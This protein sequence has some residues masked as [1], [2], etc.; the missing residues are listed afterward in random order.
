MLKRC[1]PPALL[2]SPIPIW[3]TGSLD[4]ATLLGKIQPSAASSSLQSSAVHKM[5]SAMISSTEWS[6]CPDSGEDVLC[7]RNCGVNLFAESTVDKTESGASI[8]DSSIAGTLNDFSP[9]S[10]ASGN[11]FPES[12]AVAVVDGGIK[13][14]CTIKL[15]LIDEA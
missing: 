10:S 11:N 2:G 6:Q 8:T 4:S 5:T 14:C 12:G 1:S 7:P 3:T 9:D 13:W 15:V